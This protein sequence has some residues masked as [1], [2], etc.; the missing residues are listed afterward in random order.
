MRE[1]QSTSPVNQTN[2]PSNGGWIGEL[3]TLIIIL[4]NYRLA[5]VQ[6]VLLTMSVGKKKC[7]TTRKATRNNG[8]YLLDTQVRAARFVNTYSTVSMYIIVHER[9]YCLDQ[10]GQKGIG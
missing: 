9:V 1:G 4:A 6:E 3:Y 10:G 8:K 5:P 2:L 7:T